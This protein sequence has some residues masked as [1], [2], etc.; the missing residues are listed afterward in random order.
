MALQSR[1]VGSATPA[2]YMVD[3]HEYTTNGDE[4]P[5]WRKFVPFEPFAEIVREHFRLFIENGG[6]VRKTMRLI[7]QK[8]LSFPNTLPPKGY[9][10]NSQL[11]H[12]EA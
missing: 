8:R 4:N 12:F 9:K 1:W 5:N 3:M 2:G 6:N 10:I 7:R 11:R